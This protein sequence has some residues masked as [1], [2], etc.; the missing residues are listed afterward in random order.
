MARAFLRMLISKETE[1]RR[2]YDV[3][4]RLTGVASR[5][6]GWISDPDGLNPLNAL[7][8]HFPNEVPIARNVREWLE[9]GK[10][11]VM[12]EVTSLNA[13]TGQPAIEHLMAALESGAH[14]IT[15]NKGP[16]VHGY[17]ELTAL[18]KKRSGNSCSNQ[19]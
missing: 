10:V 19:R 8:G 18:A 17:R 13:P 3:R 7:A 6:I 14:A 5:R 15:A 1:L 11:D 9:H 4:W 2:K 16:L 12:F